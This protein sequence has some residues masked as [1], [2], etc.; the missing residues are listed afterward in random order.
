[1]KTNMSYPDSISIQSATLF[2]YLYGLFFDVKKKELHLLNPSD[3]CQ[4]E[5]CSHLA[6]H[7]SLVNSHLPRVREWDSPRGQKIRFQ[8]KQHTHSHICTQAWTRTRTEWLI[9]LCCLFFISFASLSFFTWF[10]HWFRINVEPYVVITW[11][12]EKEK[13]STQKRFQFF[14]WTRTVVVQS[15]IFIHNDFF[16]IPFFYITIHC[17]LISLSFS[18]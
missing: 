6:L 18:I 4:T 17:I 12:N 8:I 14:Q 2:L 3:W 5:W 15:R 9:G 11:A 13:F 10:E 16:D 7:S 1:M